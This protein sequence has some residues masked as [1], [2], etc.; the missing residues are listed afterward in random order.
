LPHPAG[1]TEAP[2]VALFVRCAKRGNWTAASIPPRCRYRAPGWD[3]PCATRATEA[4]YARRVRSVSAVALTESDSRHLRAPPLR[5]DALGSSSSR[6]GVMTEVLFDV[7]GRRRS[8]AT[9]PGFGVGRRRE[10]DN[11]VPPTCARDRRRA[12]GVWAFRSLYARAR[13]PTSHEAVPRGR[14]RTGLAK[15]QSAG[16]PARARA[17][18]RP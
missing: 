17:G 13:G 1:A 11:S 6:G 16:R 5:G 18:A 3:G 4:P 8:P 15:P 12:F 2:R 14:A 9:L 10:S 7:V